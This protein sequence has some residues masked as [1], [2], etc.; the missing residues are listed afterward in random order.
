MCKTSLDDRYGR[1]EFE[2]ANEYDYL[3]DYDCCNYVS[4]QWFDGRTRYERVNIYCIVKCIRIPSEIA[5]DN[6]SQ[7]NK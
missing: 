4:T 2:K 6:C 7:S 1:N 3:V 5:S